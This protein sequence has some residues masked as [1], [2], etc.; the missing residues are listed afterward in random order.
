MLENLLL[1]ARQVG[2]LFLLMAV[3][4]LLTR[5]G[6][7]TAQTLPQL[8]FLLLF[9]VTPCVILDAMQLEHGDDMLPSLAL[10]SALL[11][12][13]YLLFLLALP[14]FFRRARPDTGAALRFG[15]LYS[16]QGFMGF[17]LIQSILGP[18]AMLYAMPSY[19]LFQVFS[20]THGVWLM[21][22]RKEVSLK[23]LILSPPILAAI[24]GIGLF[25]THTVLPPMAGSAVGFLADLNTP[26]AMVVIGGQMAGADLPA[27]F[28]NRALY[29]SAA[30]KLIAVP[31]VT[32]LLLLPFDLPP[33]LY[34]ASVILM[35][36]PTAGVT[37]MFSE[38]YHRD[39]KTAAQAV[40][41]STLL[42]ILTLPVFA[43]LAQTLSGLS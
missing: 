19:L 2:V 5:A 15:T 38:Q 23:K 22:G 37:A 39:G 33:L 7:L 3:G 26:L 27:T 32:A 10:G 8:S 34:C 25:L 17:P 4:F 40:T 42:S 9:V 16:N 29:G 24:A 35:A 31:A 21:G 11:V 20:W 28:R 12:G 6:K 1:V 18:G 13:C 30:L 41:L 43:V 36:T 14:L